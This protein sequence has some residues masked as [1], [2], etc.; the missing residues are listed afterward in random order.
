MVS[1][2]GPKCWGMSR[3]SDST[4]PSKSAGQLLRQRLGVCRRLHGQGEMTLLSATHWARHSRI[5]LQMK[6]GNSSDT[7]CRAGP[8]N[9]PI[10]DFP[11][12]PNGDSRTSG[13]IV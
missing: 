13:G 4:S 2:T 11:T 8:I 9:V 7:S 12:P 3:R 6:I 1:N 10:P 5:S